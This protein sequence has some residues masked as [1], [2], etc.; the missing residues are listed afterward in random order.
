MRF[1]GFAS[2]PGAMPEYAH[3]LADRIAWIVRDQAIAHGIDVT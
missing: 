1:D 2:I 3:D